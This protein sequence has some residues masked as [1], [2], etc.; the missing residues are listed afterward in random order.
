VSSDESVTVT[1]GRMVSIGMVDNLNVGMGL[2]ITAGDSITL[3][4]GLASIIM[5]NNGCITIQGLDI[6]INGEGEIAASA[7]GNM[8]FKGLKIQQN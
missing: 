8:T 5:N 6:T 1:G 2:V 3:T 7:C 4:T